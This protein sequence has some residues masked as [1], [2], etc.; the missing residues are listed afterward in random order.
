MFH[1][2]RAGAAFARETGILAA[3]YDV[4]I[5][6]DD[7]NLLNPDYAQIAWLVLQDQPETAI[8]GGN[9]VAEYEMELPDWSSALSGQ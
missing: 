1:E 9:S 4:L 7:D 6:C 8:V 5:F 2:P 3:S